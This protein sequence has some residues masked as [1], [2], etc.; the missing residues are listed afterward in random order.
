MAEN[1]KKKDGKGGVV[2]TD[3]EKIALI[4]TGKP[5][6]NLGP[7]RERTRKLIEDQQKK[8]KK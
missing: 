5:D 4:K 6:G 3:E 7:F 1:K 2:L 8:R